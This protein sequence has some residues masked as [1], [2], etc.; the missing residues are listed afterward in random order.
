[1]KENLINKVVGNLTDYEVGKLFIARFAPNWSVEKVTDQ[2]NI[3][4]IQII[5]EWGDCVAETEIDESED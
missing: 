2:F 1:M 4:S 5:D 3:K